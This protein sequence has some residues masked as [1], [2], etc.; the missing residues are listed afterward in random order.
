MEVGGGGKWGGGGKDVLKGGLSRNWVGLEEVEGVGGGER[1]W[2]RLFLVR[3]E[4]VGGLRNIEGGRVR[5]MEGNGGE[6]EGIFDGVGFGMG[7]E[8]G[9]FLVE[10]SVGGMG[11][12]RGLMEGGERW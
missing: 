9:E 1:G 2:G 10:G 11:V 4:G 8:G 7:K 12:E 6:D 5:W 3:G